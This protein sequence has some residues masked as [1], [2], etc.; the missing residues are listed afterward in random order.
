MPLRPLIVHFLLLKL[1]FY[2]LKS[3]LLKHFFNLGAHLGHLFVGA[4]FYLI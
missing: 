4:E 1:P 3:L 2:F